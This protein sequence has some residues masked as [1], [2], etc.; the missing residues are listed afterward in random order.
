MSQ[1]SKGTK[2]GHSK[3]LAEL[4]KSWKQA[5]Q[6]FLQ[7][8]E[9]ADKPDI[10]KS[11]ILLHCIGKQ[12]K[13]IY[14]TFEFHEGDEMKLN[15]ILQKFDDHFKPRKKLTFMRFTFFTVRQ[16]DFEKF[17]EYYTRLCKLSE[18]CVNSINSSGFSH[19]RH[20]HYRFKRQ[21]T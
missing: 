16:E 7:A 3:N 5:F 11:S 15:I 6:I 20:D 18:D 1:G 10:V 8:T 9:S 4:W 14:D 12:C 21:K 19:Q 2:L 13:E 17:D